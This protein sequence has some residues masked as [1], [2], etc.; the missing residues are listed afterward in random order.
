[1]RRAGGLKEKC[2]YNFVRHAR[3]SS[4]T[5]GNS[6]ESYLHIHVS[7][8]IN[9]NFIGIWRNEVQLCSFLSQEEN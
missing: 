6:I 7:R 1:M 5:Y 9:V 2:K 3:K 8:Q 4:V